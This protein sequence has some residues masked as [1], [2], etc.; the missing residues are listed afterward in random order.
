ML[1][2]YFT[3]GSGLYLCYVMDMELKMLFVAYFFAC[4]N[5]GTMKML[6]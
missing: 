3:H 2:S 6:I 4:V 1:A 5:C